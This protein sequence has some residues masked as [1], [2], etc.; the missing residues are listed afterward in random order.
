MCF[1]NR[2]NRIRSWGHGAHPLQ[3]IKVSTHLTALFVGLI[4]LRGTA[5]VKTARSSDPNSEGRTRLVPE[6]SRGISGCRPSGSNARV[7]GHLDEPELSRAKEAT[8]G[9]NGSSLIG[10]K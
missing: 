9:P 4:L 10:Q 3:S 1:A 2:E 6:R 7:C 5:Q 8:W